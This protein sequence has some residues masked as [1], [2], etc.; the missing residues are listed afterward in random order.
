M[1]Q[2]DLSLRLW[3]CG[4]DVGLSTDPEKVNAYVSGLVPPLQDICIAVRILILESNPQFEETWRWS[5]PVYALGG[6]NICYF[7]ANNTSVNIGF[8]QGAHLPDPHQLLQG[9]GANMRHVKLKSVNELDLEAITALILEAC[10]RH[11]S[12]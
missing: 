5:R 11:R 3:T 1:K 12:T 10:N 7:V 4:Y 8:E 9:T 2:L 6:K